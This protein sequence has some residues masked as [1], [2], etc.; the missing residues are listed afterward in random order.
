M[1]ILTTPSNPGNA[2]WSSSGALGIP[3]VYSSE[4]FESH[5]DTTTSITPY[6]TMELTIP[7]DTVSPGDVVSYNFSSS[8]GNGAATA[9]QVGFRYT[10]GTTSTFLS[11]SI[12]I[13]LNDWYNFVVQVQMVL[14]SG[15]VQIM[16]PYV[17]AE[18]DNAVNPVLS[19]KYIFGPSFDPTQDIT[20]TPIVKFGAATNVPAYVLQPNIIVNLTH[21]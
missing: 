4:S 17:V 11:D 3:L 9:I 14:S 10:N 13:P 5:L 6:P 16:V 1:L 7:A 20:I 19:L 8:A 21:S 18:S 15:G 12:N 2:S